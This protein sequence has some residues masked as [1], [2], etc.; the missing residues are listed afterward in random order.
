MSQ[1]YV[2]QGAILTC[3]QGIAPTTLRVTSN[4]TVKSQNKL[5]ATELDK[6]PFVNIP[7]FGGCRLIYPHP[8][9]CIP[10][11]IMWTDTHPTNK[12][13]NAK[14]LLKKSTIP[15]AIGGKI[16]ITNP[17][18]VIA[19]T[20][21]KVEGVKV[22]KIVDVVQT[23]FDLAGLIPVV[24]E[25]FDGLNAAIYTVRGDYTNAA[26]SAAAMVPVVGM[27]ATGG[28][29]IKKGVSVLGHFP[30][31]MNIGEKIGARVFKIPTKY[32]N[33]MTEAQKWMSNKKFL[34]RM[35]KRGDDIMLATPI[36]KIKPGSYYQKEIQYLFEKG[37]K[38][39]PDGRYLIK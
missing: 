28:K 1:K 13:C 29:T 19:S 22:E 16:S 12:C 3:N 8:G 17:S 35:I 32:W 30:E 11:P 20:G 24:G 38:L 4:F 37:Y 36:N 39:S 15:C 6:A 23:V 27:A 21:A 9:P 31:Y 26:L 34:D 5:V 14:S 7:S 18:Q 10:S 2:T 33:E 25:F